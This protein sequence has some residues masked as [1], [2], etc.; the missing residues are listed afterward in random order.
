MRVTFND[1]VGAALVLMAGAV[2]SYAAL[3]GVKAGSAE[4]MTALVGIVGAGVGYFLRGR[5]TP[6]AA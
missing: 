4:A 6:P 2:V 3:F 5:V 1:A